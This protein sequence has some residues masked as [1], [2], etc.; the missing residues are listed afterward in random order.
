MKA[1]LLVKQPLSIS[2][3]TNVQTRDIHNRVNN[4][5]N[6]VNK[7]FSKVFSFFF[8]FFWDNYEYHFLV[9]E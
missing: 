7:K 8:F 2:L 1:Y 6:D 9:L 3:L 4:M 5:K